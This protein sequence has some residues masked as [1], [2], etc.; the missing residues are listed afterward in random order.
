MIFLVASRVCSRR[1]AL[2][3]FGR[4]LPFGCWFITGLYSLMIGAAEADEPLADLRKS[5]VFYASFDRTSDARIAE[6]DAAIYTATDLSRAQTKRGLH[7]DNVQIAAGEG[8]FGDCLRFQGRSKEVLFYRGENIAYRTRDWSGTVALWM[9]LSPDQDLMPGYCDPIQITEKGWNDGAFF[10]D[11]DK[12]LPRDFRLGVFA[13][14]KF[15][16]PQDIS[17]DDLPV[18]QRPMVVVKPPTFSRDRWTH[19][20]WTF[21]GVNAGDAK[22]ARA[23]LFIDGEPRGAVERPL[24]FTW[25]V[26]RSA[27]MLGIEYIGDLDELLIFDRPLEQDELKAV[28]R[29]SF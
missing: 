8:K 10:I 27:I 25:N 26:E 1:I 14:Y 3:S 5:I 18:D 15:W 24:Q 28:M 6:G 21:E 16:N 20:A 11:F 12:E 2:S 9:R 29:Q 23:T 17:W 19:V 4:T 7:R 22:E 13:D